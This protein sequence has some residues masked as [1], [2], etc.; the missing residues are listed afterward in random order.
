MKLIKK[1]QQDVSYLWKVHWQGDD[2]CL[3]NTRVLKLINNTRIH[4]LGR[5]YLQNSSLVKWTRLHLS[6]L[7]TNTVCF[8]FSSLFF[9]G[10]LTPKR[11]VC[12]SSSVFFHSA[13]NSG[14]HC[15]TLPHEVLSG[16]ATFMGFLI[17]A[18]PLKQNQK[19]DQILAEALPHWQ[20]WWKESS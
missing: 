14:L 3:K 8:L 5:L 9:S 12:L 18:K 13:L 16:T 2:S 20:A 15:S 11:S 6:Q 1:W 4:G 17:K 7:T 10:V 19:E